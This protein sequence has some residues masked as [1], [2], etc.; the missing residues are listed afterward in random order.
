M[1]PLSIPVMAGNEWKYIKECLDTGW[2]SSV[3][4]FVNKFEKVLAEYTGTQHAI[5]TVNG[6]AALHLSLIGCGVGAD[7]EVVVPA[8]TFIAPANAVRY[9]GAYPVFMDCDPLTLC[10]DVEKLS[11]FFQKE[12]SKSKDGR[13]INKKTKR[14]IKAVIPVHVFGH[15]AD[16][17]ALCLLS[18]KYKIPVI[19]DAT[20]SIGSEYKGKRTG[21]FGELGCFS[22]NGNKIVT[23]GGGGMI[24]TDNKAVA[25]RVRHLSTQAKKDPIEYDHDEIGYNYRL[26]NVLAAMGVA[27]MEKLADFIEIKRKNASRYRELLADVDEIDF[28]WEQPWAKSNF[29]FYTIRF[30]KKFKRPLMQYLLGQDIQVRPIWK[31]LH[32][33]PMFKDCTAYKIEESVKAYETSLNLPCSVNLKPEEIEFVAGC[34]K[35]FFTQQPALKPR[36][37]GAGSPR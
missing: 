22:F 19:E 23:T 26:T 31:L 32:T 27:Q 28:L 15:P 36:Y 17:N 30:P 11:V 6:T 29:W 14:T 3:G 18:R 7:D 16:L 20:E 13:L 2:V 9:C 21:S 8:L 12:C 35:K 4:P 24:V 34:V 37:D 5:A 1:I 33:L 10:I 25:D